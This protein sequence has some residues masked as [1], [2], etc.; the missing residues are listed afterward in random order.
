MRLTELGLRPTTLARLRS[1]GINTTYR[2]L[3]HTCRELTW[4]SEIDATD[5]YNILRVL[6]QHGL[7]LK[8]TTKGKTP[9]PPGERNLEIFRL[10]VVEGRPLK[11]TGER[12]GIGVERVRQVLVI[13]FGL[14]GALPAIKPAASAK[15]GRPNE[16]RA[17]DVRRRNQ[18]GA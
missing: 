11:E 18:R 13:Y 1:A 5:L 7:A 10:R 17:L 6:N 12:V 15:T 4:H 8:A 14:R 3:E 2:L 16:L 9:R